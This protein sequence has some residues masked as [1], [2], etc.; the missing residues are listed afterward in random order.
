VLYSDNRNYGRGGGRENSRRSFSGNS[1]IGGRSNSKIYNN[2]ISQAPPRRNS[3]R[4]DDLPKINPDRLGDPAQI[5]KNVSKPL[6]AV[7][8][9]A[10]FFGS[11]KNQQNCL[12]RYV[13]SDG[14]NQFQVGSTA[15]SWSGGDGDL[16]AWDEANLAGNVGATNT[17]SGESDSR[18][19]DSDTVGPLDFLLLTADNSNAGGNAGSV[20]DSLNPANAGTKSF[21]VPARCLAPEM[22]RT[23]QGLSPKQQTLLLSAGTLPTYR[24]TNT[25]NV[26]YLGKFRH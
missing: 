9:L 3:L 23:I 25:S 20:S 19:S 10:I 16:L 2:G 22:Q 26:L 21:Q 17:N 12:Q 11:F 18:D 1:Q 15:V 8:V 24:Y 14:D 13:T 6:V 5:F 4:C 7:I